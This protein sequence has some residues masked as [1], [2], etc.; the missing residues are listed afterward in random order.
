MIVDV[1]RVL[2]F[3]F[4]SRFTFLTFFLFR[5]RIFYFLKDVVEV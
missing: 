2:R 4:T 5:P 3:L 1:K